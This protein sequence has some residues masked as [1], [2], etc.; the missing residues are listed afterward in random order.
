MSR[1]T[2]ARRWLWKRRA[3]SAVYVTAAPDGPGDHGAFLGGASARDIVDGAVGL[4]ND[5]PAFLPLGATTVTFTAKDRSGNT[6]SATSTITVTK[7]AVAPSKPLDR[8]PPDDVRGLAAIRKSH[9]TLTR[10]ASAIGTIGRARSKRR[11][12]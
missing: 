12:R 3:L 10:A 1:P 2:R 9:E 11:L 7:A 4:T 6:V 5:A 8:T